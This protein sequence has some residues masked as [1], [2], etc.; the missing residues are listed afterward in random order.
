MTLNR[1]NIALEVYDDYEVYKRLR[2]QAL[3]RL[4]SEVPEFH[5]LRELAKRE[6]LP[7]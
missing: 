1:A 4:I 6:N 5:K 2:F 7:E 3:D